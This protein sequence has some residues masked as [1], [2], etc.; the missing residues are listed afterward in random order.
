MKVSKMCSVRIL[1]NFKVF[2]KKY[3]KFEKY[4]QRTNEHVKIV[5]REEKKIQTFKKN[6]QTLQKF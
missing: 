1:Q 5:P 4:S 6:P 2:A 3:T